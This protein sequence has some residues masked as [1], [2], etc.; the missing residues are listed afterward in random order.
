MPL[1]R[2]PGLL[3]P[4]KPLSDGTLRTAFW[5]FKADIMRWI[6]CAPAYL[7]CLTSDSSRETL[8]PPPR[9]AHQMVYDHVRKQF[10]IHGGNAGKHTQKRLDDFWGMKLQRYVR[11]INMGNKK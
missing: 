9:Y 4:K 11:Y 7:T 6:E 2:L 1:H 5:I 8:E 3:K 10:F